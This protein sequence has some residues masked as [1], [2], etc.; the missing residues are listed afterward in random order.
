MAFKLRDPHVAL[1]PV[2]QIIQS[3]DE[4]GLTNPDTANPVTFHPVVTMSENQTLTLNLP[5]KF[6]ELI[7]VEPGLPVQVTKIGADK[8]YY[9]EGTIH[10]IEKGK[11]SNIT[12]QHNG[13]ILCAQ[14]RLFYRFDLRRPCSF[15][16]ITQPDGK[17]ISRLKA[18]IQD[19]SPSGIGFSASRRLPQG[20]QFG[21]GDLFQAVTSDMENL[22]YYM[23]VMWVKGNRLFGYRH[24]AVFKFASEKDQDAFG[25]VLSRLQIDRL[26]WYYHNAL[27][28]K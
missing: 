10:K 14:R 28:R 2:D 6:W 16:N 19:M 27:A 22:N 8:M 5:E 17:I 26:S 3:G 15:K 24:G 12:L 1:K 21:V 13:E 18:V 11:N 25:R 9:I 7:R 23:Q 4:I 20:T